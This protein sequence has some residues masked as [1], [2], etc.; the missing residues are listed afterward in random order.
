MPKI[1]L[2]LLGTGSMA[3]QHAAQFRDMKDVQIVG[4]VDVDGARLT[5]FCDTFS[6]PHRFAD[7]KA[8]LQWG[9]F[10]AV[11]NVTPDGAHHPTTMACIK[12]GKHVFCEKPLATNATDARAMRDAAHKADIIGMVNLTYRNGAAMSKAHQ[13]VADGAIGTVRHVQAA[14]LQSWLTQPAWGDWREHHQWLWRL[15]T[16]HGSGGVLGD[17]GVHLVDFTSFIAGDSFSEL[18]CRL[19]TFAKA[20]KDR[21]GDYMLD[22]NDSFVIHAQMA[23]GALAVLHASRWASGHINDLRLR[24]HG[25]QGGLEVVVRPQGDT[26]RGCLGQKDM[27]AGTWREL[28]T[29]PVKTMYER[30]IN[31]VRAGQQDEPSF[32]LGARI[33]GV[34]DT[35]IASDQA[36]KVLPCE[37]ES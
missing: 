12:A 24:I 23:G 35:C 3:N 7:L 26:L 29:P 5:T 32:A 25:D 22:A 33:Q 10:D 15:S 36:G 4:G 13:L 30:F 27:T 11:A 8:A 16:A 2:L 34:L 14:Y 37:N 31:A 6:I 18:S 20:P 21:I 9:E 1:K 19:K 28:K 17:V